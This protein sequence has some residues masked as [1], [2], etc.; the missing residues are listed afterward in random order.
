MKVPAQQI[1][2]QAEQAHEADEKAKFILLKLAPD[3]FEGTAVDV[4]AESWPVV[5]CASPLAVR[6][7]MRKHSAAKTPVVLTYGGNDHDLGMDVLARCAKRRAIPHDLWQT[8]LALFRAAHIDPRLARHRWLAELLVR[9]MPAEGYMPVRS[10]V[11]DQDR[12]W[13]ELLRVVLG[14][15]SSPPTE[16]D[17][18]KW[19]GDALRREQFKS[20]DEPVR[21]EIVQHLREALGELVNFVFAAVEV[22]SADELIAIAMLCESLNDQSAATEAARAKVSARLEVLFGGLTLST[23]AMQQLAT[24]ANAWFDRAGEPAKQHQVARYEA[25]VT[26]LK[27]DALAS[28]ARYGTAALREK[29][30][31][32]AHSL[33]ALNLSDS[34]ARLQELM[35]QRG[36]VLRAASELR[37]RMALRLTSWLA[38]QVPPV[39]GSLS[40]LAEQYRKDVAWVDWAQTVLFEGDDSADLAN[41]YGLIREKVRVRRDG[42]D[43]Q[44]AEALAADKPDGLSLL[45][46][47]DSLG[48][49][50]APVAAAGRCLLIVVDGMSIPVFLE[51]HQSLRDHG[52]V[53]FER[54][55]APCPTLLAMLPSTTAASRTSLLCGVATTGSASTERAAF[56]AFP[57]LVSLSVAGKPPLIFHKR[58]LLDASGTSLSEDLRS[59]LGDARQRVVAVVINAVDDHLTKAD[60]LRLRWDVSQ[61]K[62]LDALLAEARSSDRLVVFASDHGHVLDQ[63]MVMQ[64]S[65]PNA[66]WR[67]PNLESY[68]GEI[69]LTGPRVKTATGLDGG[70]VLAWSSKLRYAGKRNGHHGGCS[71]AEALVP[72][73][74]YRYSAKAPEGWTAVDEVPPD[75]WHA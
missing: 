31:A 74:T 18:L 17:L 5:A 61:F 19:A 66:R 14:F 53:Q 46:I 29:T 22:D 67:E 3:A 44:F 41:A 36:P 54:E 12:A 63:D 55:G 40:L 6:D 25:L 51:L 42:F 34:K 60:Q 50:I 75:W 16:L 2:L 7:A 38:Q 71:P 28:R 8:V 27:A 68:P 73:S 59:A 9:F 39:S 37:C 49:C 23:R 24:A 72:L 56:S 35:S 52:W 69:V 47:E 26:Q 62:G 30:K 20:L 4:K 1:K 11:L 48:K 33:T 58:D 57:V 21:H 45:P 32:F 65:S 13:K 64:G 15:E 70:V 43:S 10:L